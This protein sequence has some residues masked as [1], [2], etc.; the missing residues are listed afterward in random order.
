[1]PVKIER[2]LRKRAKEKYDQGKLKPKKGETRQDTINRYVYGGLRNLGY[3][4][5][6][7]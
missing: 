6:R 5:G 7:R 3:P 4:V 2:H 1:M